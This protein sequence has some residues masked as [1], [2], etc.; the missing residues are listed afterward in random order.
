[1]TLP[2]PSLRLRLGAGIAAALGVSLCAFSLVL[3]VAFSRA[4]WRQFDERLAQEARAVA[5]MVEERE[6]DPWEIEPAVLDGFGSP[7]GVAYFE[8]WMDDGTVLARSPSLGTRDLDRP[9]PNSDTVVVEST[10]ASGKHGR[11][12]L[13]SLLP[14][15]DEE[16]PLRPS[17][18][19]M[20]VAVARATDEVD[21][22]LATLRLLLW[23]SA[24]AALSL[25]VLAG[26]LAIRKGLAPVARLAARLDGMGSQRLDE[27]LPT[28]D[29]PRE[30]RPAVLRLNEL[31]GRLESSFQ[32]E[33]QFSADVSHELRT[34]LAGLRSLIE[35]AASRERPA[36][37]YKAALEDGLRIVL[38]MHT[39]VE[40]LLLMARLEARQVGVVTEE[41]NLRML[42]AECFGPFAA[43]ADSRGLRFENLI[44]DDLTITSDREKLRI[45]LNN[46][47][48]NAVE[49]T[50]ET[51]YVVVESS[52]SS[53]DIFAV[54]DSGPAIPESV[55]AKIF[56]RFFRSDS[57]RAKTG[58]HCGVG[59]A[60]ARALCQ[61]L[62]LAIVAENRRDGWVAF[63]IRRAATP[64]A[65][66]SQPAAPPV[67]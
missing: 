28:E 4:L 38:Q 15:H 1:V 35:V 7:Y 10:L 47:L 20:T 32:R 58:E 37:E 26:W 67:P 53:A 46:L 43:K 21:A 34:P 57:S 41:I 3:Y 64:I 60:L 62:G 24:L 56:D 49:Y 33:H 65:R 52:T 44:P 18:R 51:G 27:R 6:Q 13:A 40:N 14:R 2:P 29:L 42:V 8:I 45:V 5:N 55:L 39:L 17:G 36:A 63:R 31:L 25:A 66:R 19:R 16:G 12:L 11:L 9:R 61:V 48:A 59:L 50:E 22:T 23:L 30:L 54:C